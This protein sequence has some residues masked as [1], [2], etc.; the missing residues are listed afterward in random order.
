MKKHLAIGSCSM[1]CCFPFRFHHNW[2]HL[3]AL[4][5]LATAALS[6]LGQGEALKHCQERRLTKCLQ[7]KKHFCAFKDRG[8][9]SIVLY[10]LQSTFLA[11]PGLCTRAQGPWS[12]KKSHVWPP[13]CKG[14]S[15]AHSGIFGSFVT[16]VQ[17]MIHWWPQEAWKFGIAPQGPRSGSALL[18]GGT[19]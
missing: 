2:T 1:L 5:R 14:Y 9:K 7:L 18:C 16:C 4:Q 13:V 8:F 11:P 15:E 12:T 6:H 3:D 17:S 10:L 19:H